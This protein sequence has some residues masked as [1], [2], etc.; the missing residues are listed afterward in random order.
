MV[1]GASDGA[2][3]TFIEE[4]ALAV[5]AHRGPA[6]RSLEYRERDDGTID[7]HFSDGRFFFHLDLRE[8]RS[9]AVHLCGE[10]RYEIETIVV[11]RDR[12]EERWR[13]FGPTKDY[14]ASTI[15]VRCV[16]DGTC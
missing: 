4:G 9:T 13:V 8:E 15:W 7:V 14:E 2:R 3:A 11:D 1:T 10:D 5:G 6:S 12:L 16:S